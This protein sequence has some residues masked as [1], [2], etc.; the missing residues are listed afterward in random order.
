MADFNQNHDR[1]SLPLLKPTQFIKL[2]VLFS[3]LLLGLIFTSAATPLVNMIFGEG[4]R[5]ALL[6]QSVVQAICAFILPAWT[7]VRIFRKDTSNAL[8]IVTCP[9][10][11]AIIAMIACMASALPML[12]EIISLNASMQLPDTVAVLFK[13]WEESSAVLTNRMLNTDSIGGLVSGILV[14][15]VMTGFAEEIFFR[16]ALQP[17]LRGNNIGMHGAIWLA[18]IVFSIMHFQPYGFFPRLLLGAFFGYLYAWS[19]S[20]WLNATAHALNN[21]MVVV[22]A[23]LSHRGT[24]ISIYDT[25]GTPE[26]DT[27][28]LTAASAVAT[29]IAIYISSKIIKQRH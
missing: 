9:S 2:T 4:T 27:L 8:G 1:I 6:A 13:E 17:M 3:L 7:C 20:I 25:I 29:A 24:D 19:G 18:A 5:A 22:V 14:I 11:G 26:S 21:S 15:G 10:V 28:W 16:G 12:N 23:W